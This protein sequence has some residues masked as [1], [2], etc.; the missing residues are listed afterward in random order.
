MFADVSFPISSY[1]IFSYKIPKSLSGKV[2]VGMRVKAMFGRRK[3]QGIVVKIKKIS[4]FKGHIRPIESLVDDQPVLDPTLWKLINWLA[5]IGR[6][7]CR[8]RV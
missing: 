5:E 8:E 1:Q 7:S 6:A 2:A 3:A 4:E